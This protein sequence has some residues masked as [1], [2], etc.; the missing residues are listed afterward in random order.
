MFTAGKKESNQD[1]VDL[2]N[3]SFS[4]D[5]L[6]IVMDSIYTGDLNVN[7]E[8]VFGVLAAAYRLQVTTDVQQFCDVIIR[9]FIQLRFDLP[10]YC[11]LSTVADRHVLRDLQEAAEQTMTSIYVNGYESQKIPFRCWCR[12]VIQ[13]PQ[14][15]CRRL[16]EIRKIR[17]IPY[18]SILLSCK[19]FC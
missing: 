1:V 7:E 19:P 11:L 15:R 8:N 14:S 13:P 6:K 4:T 17:Y 9:E 3:K 10:N 16:C 12:P 5:V 18:I 2:N